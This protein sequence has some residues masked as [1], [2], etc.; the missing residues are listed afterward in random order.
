MRSVA[1]KNDGLIN[2]PQEQK[3]GFQ[4]YFPRFDP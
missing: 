2:T 4:K 3:L 1:E